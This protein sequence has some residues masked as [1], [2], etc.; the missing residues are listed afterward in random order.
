MTT[1]TTHTRSRR[2]ALGGLL[3]Q[4]VAFGTTFVLSYM[5]HAQA[6]YALSWYIAGGIPIWFVALLVF[7]QREL[8]A[9]E[10]MDLE[11][12]RREKQATGG[13]E[14][15]FDRE[16]GMGL[17]FEVA[18]QRLRWML[19]WLIPGFGL[20]TAV[21]LAV[22]GV[23]LWQ[24]L[25]GNN[26]QIGVQTG[27]PTL[28]R[29]PIA[30]VVLAILMLGTFL[31]SRYTSGMGRVKEWQLLRGCGAYMLGNAI[32]ITALMVCLGV[33][34]YNQKVQSW[35]HALAY[36]IPVLMLILAVEILANF[37]LDIYRP[38]TPGVEPR[39]C[40]DSRLL[41]LLAEPGGIAHSVAEALNYQF[42]FKVSQTWFYQLMERWLVPLALVGAVALW[43]L[44]SVVV[45]QPYEHVII[46]RFGAQLNPGG[47]DAQGEPLPEPLGP[48]LHFKWPQPIDT[49][50]AYNTGQLHQISV[51]WQEFAAEP[52]YER[53]DKDVLLWTDARH[54]G[55][56]HFDFLVCPNPSRQDATER[57]R[58]AWSEDDK[59]RVEDVPVH[60]LRMQVT[61]QYRICAD[62]LHLYSQAMSD[63]HQTIRDVAWEELV[64]FNASS[65][66]GYL[67]GDELSQIGDALRRDISARVQ[68]VGLEVVYVGVENVHPETTVAQAYR[69]V[70]QAE[71][72]KVAAIRGARVT[73]EQELSQA[74]GDVQQAQRLATT[75]E[76]ARRAAERQNTAAA[77]LRG[78]EP[79]VIERLTQELDAA[80][81]L[82][83]ARVEAATTLEDIRAR[84]AQ[85]EED[86]R[87]GLGQTLAGVDNMQAAV[88]EAE[89]ALE[90]ADRAVQPVL[91]AFQ[92]GAAQQL[93]APQAKAL[94]S[95]VE[96][97]IA[98]DYL[99]RELDAEFARPELG[100]AVAAMLAGALAS[101]W[102]L[103]MSTASELVRAENEHEA[104]RAAPRVYK[105]RR[106]IDVLV[107]GLKDARK[108]FLAFDPGDRLVRVRFVAEDKPG[109]EFLPSPE[110]KMQP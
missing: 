68:D 76:R 56:A 89:A 28:D 40:F 108:Y 66:P 53:H 11:E 90:A 3:L 57:P 109:E 105:T 13:G 62:R 65:T 37:V 22:F 20:A 14:A 100:G 84:A 94:L 38:R 97:R 75:I 41:G 93:S 43:L 33:A 104:Y 71:H 39:A 83:R 60:M 91:S 24:R 12:L 96:A 45:V 26:L 85:A 88:R 5:T 9:L 25:A 103:E 16:G 99:T 106:L 8:A 31:L 101:R 52:D 42:G 86:Y 17:A 107:E 18:E 7:R 73:Q 80:G 79:A 92:S 36:A 50:R 15:M 19:K 95:G 110:M 30:L 67:M 98:A 78:V 59:G 70:I 74:A 4:I 21:Y 58:T 81:D 55:L 32:A 35:E 72:E 63:P 29:I 44:T 10:A 47:E 82:L 77:E 87:L 27:W 1:E 2:A 54:L 23:V 64:R 49:A 46:E 6:V 51:G 102:E 34:Q 69:E 48:G 61:V